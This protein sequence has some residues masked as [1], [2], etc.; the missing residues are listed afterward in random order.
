MRKTSAGWLLLAFCLAAP[1]SV[2][3]EPNETPLILTQS[4]IAIDVAE[5]D[6]RPESKR[7]SYHVST[8]EQQAV[9]LLVRVHDD[10]PIEIGLHTF[11]GLQCRQW[12]TSVKGLK[13]V[14]DDQRRIYP[15]SFRKVFGTSSEGVDVRMS[16]LDIRRPDGDYVLLTFAGLPQDRSLD[17]EV[18]GMMSKIAKGD[19]SLVSARVSARKGLVTP[20]VVRPDRNGK[21]RLPMH[22]NVLQTSVDEEWSA[23]SYV[24]FGAQEDRVW[25][26]KD[27]KPPMTV[28]FIVADPL[29]VP[30]GKSQREAAL[31]EHEKSEKYRDP[32]TTTRLK[33]APE[34]WSTAVGVREFGGL[35]SFSMQGL[36]PDRKQLLRVFLSV[37]ASMS[38]KD[39]IAA[40]VDV[41]ERWRTSLVGVD[42]RRLELRKPVTRLAQTGLELPI[43][44]F[45]WKTKTFGKRFGTDVLE[46]KN[47]KERGEVTLSTLKFSGGCRALM[48]SVTG[49]DTE[50]H[51]M[52]GGWDV[53]T[54]VRDGENRAWIACRK[55]GADGPLLVAEIDYSKS[56]ERFAAPLVLAIATANTSKVRVSATKAPPWA[57]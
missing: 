14:A 30:D 54:K 15:R 40:V 35:K 53:S 29:L 27:G 49:A 12:Y 43:D 19:H 52:F 50:S 26:L 21:L 32:K 48:K 39:G 1:A 23:L 7:W 6:F 4:G 37:D 41:A 34:G 47:G 18:G 57:R 36:S 20:T 24:T 51:E 44:K 31:D 2:V 25:R 42:T 46:L 9:D 55:I 16:C 3:A 22:G 10:A 45:Q 56:M 33:E 38:D 28:V 11:F 5:A 13:L 17:G 8:V